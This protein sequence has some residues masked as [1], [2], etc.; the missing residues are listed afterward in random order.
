M[1]SPRPV[2]LALAAALVLPLAAAGPAPASAPVPTLV[3]IRAVH[4]DGVDRVVFRFDGGLPR[5]RAG[6]VD[7]LIGDASG[8]PVRIA[9]RAVLRVLGVEARVLV[10][11]TTEAERKRARAQTFDEMA[12]DALAEVARLA[13]RRCVEAEVKVRPTVLVHVVRV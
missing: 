4:D 6:Y 8:L 2:L 3:G 11:L 9:G 5:V 10:T 1:W 12:D 13:A 7:E